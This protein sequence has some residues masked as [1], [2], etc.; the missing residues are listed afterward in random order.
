MIRLGVHTELHGTNR[1][2]SFEKG[3]GNSVHP[4]HHPS[5]DSED[6]RDRGVHLLNE[7]HVLHHLTN[8]RFAEAATEPVVRVHFFDGSEGHLDHR[9]FSAQFD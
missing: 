1:W 4:I 8:C 2:L 7:L 9:K 5:I 6:D 3:S